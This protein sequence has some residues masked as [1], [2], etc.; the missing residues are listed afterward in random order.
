MRADHTQEY[1]ATPLSQPAPAA[2]SAKQ[3]IHNVHS[4]LSTVE[5][6]RKLQCKETQ[7]SNFKRF[8]FSAHGPAVDEC[9]TAPFP[10][11]RNQQS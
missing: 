9:Q 3:G 6:E 4:L 5:G 10:D 8:N 11:K 1:L 2:E 7:H